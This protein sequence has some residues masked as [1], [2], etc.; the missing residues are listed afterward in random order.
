MKDYFG[1][2]SGCGKSYFNS[3]NYYGSG[4]S[5]TFAKEIRL[6]QEE[7]ASLLS[8]MDMVKKRLRINVL[9]TGFETQARTVTK[10]REN[11][12][13]YIIKYGVPKDGIFDLEKLAE[14]SSYA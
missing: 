13:Q 14:F 10:V 8:D 9:G 3:C 12:V 4:E 5:A 11:Y 1:C 7:V 6:L 2:G